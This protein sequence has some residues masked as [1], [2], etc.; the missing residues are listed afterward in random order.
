MNG[1]KRYPDV[2]QR[3]SRSCVPIVR[4]FCRVAPGDALD[5]SVEL[6]EVLDLAHA[7]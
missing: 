2:E 7:L 1:E 3:V 5:F 6:V 4:S